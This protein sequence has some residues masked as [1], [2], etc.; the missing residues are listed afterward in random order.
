MIES[1]PGALRAL[2]AARVP[3]L[4]ITNGGGT[5]EAAKAAS[6]GTKMGV[7]FAED[8]IILSH[9]PMRAL[10]ARHGND[11]VLVSGRCMC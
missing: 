8:E 2:R 6:L 5:L 9:T 1:A 10:A 3:L 4:G 7:P 11:L